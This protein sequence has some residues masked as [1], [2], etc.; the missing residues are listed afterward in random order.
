[1]GPLLFYNVCIDYRVWHPP[2]S[3]SSHHC[4]TEKMARRWT[5]QRLLIALVSHSPPGSVLTAVED[6]VLLPPVRVVPVDD[7]RRQA[8]KRPTGS[9]EV[10]RAI[11][12]DGSPYA[13]KP[14]KAGKPTN[15]KPP[16]Q[17]R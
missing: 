15:A 2:T 6:L 4:A 1:M 16:A 17:M 5:R 10:N 3:S 8:N 9:D 7:L 12:L 11:M 13:G 14:T